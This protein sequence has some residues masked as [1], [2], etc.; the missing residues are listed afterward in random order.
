M[1]A[2]LS[3]EQIGA[4]GKTMRSKS[5]PFLIVEDDEVDLMTIKRALKDAHIPNPLIHRANGEEALVYLRDPANVKP[6][7]IF[8][9]LNMPC[10]SGLEFLAAM[11]QDKQLRCF[12]S[13]VLTTS[14]ETSD[15][16]SSF[17]LQAA[18]YV[19]KRADYRQFVEVMRTID[20][21]WTMS[22]AP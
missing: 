17:D 21:Y 4:K 22:E 13:I 3:R 11:N 9:D 5:S 15:K 10:M 18:G 19:V 20:R 14:E 1:R 12:P 6:C 8:V 2:I 16:V 7:M